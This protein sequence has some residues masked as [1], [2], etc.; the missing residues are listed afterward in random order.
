MNKYYFVYIL[1]NDIDTVLY[2]GVTSDLRKRVFQH[3]EK[4]VDG[5]T[6]KYNVSKLVYF[7]TFED[8]YNAISREK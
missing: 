4:M 1:S 7:E 8:P 3:R 2:T 5:F 6:K